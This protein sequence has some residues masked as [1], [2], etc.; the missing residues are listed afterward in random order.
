MDLT[1]FWWSLPTWLTDKVKPNGKTTLSFTAYKADDGYW[2][3]NKPALL[4]WKESLVFTDALNELAGDSTKLDMT[5]SSEPIPGA[6]KAWYCQD[7]PLDLTASH[8]YWGDHLIW[9]CGWLPWYFGDKP[10]NLWF[11]AD[12]A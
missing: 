7:D 1:N 8:Y 12:P 10:E 2:Y 6:H 9:L 3:F 4:T 11:T 5:L